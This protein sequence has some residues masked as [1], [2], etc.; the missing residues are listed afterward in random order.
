MR[1]KPSRADVEDVA[2][3]AILIGIV[4][5]LTLVALLSAA[6]AHQ[7]GPLMPPGVVAQAF[8]T[9]PNAP[10]QD[11]KQP[12][13]WRYGWECCSGMDCQELPDTAVHE[14]PDG[15]TIDGSADTAPVSY[16]DPKRIKQSKDEH[17][18]WCA[19]RAGND[20][21]KTIC[22]YVPGRGY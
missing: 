16:N 10:A 20:L 8:P 17:F 3:T 5:G 6:W 14:T 15:Y 2:V 22:L 21:N 7:A 19:H 11:P 13:G 9:P 12:L 4:A 18:H 1:S